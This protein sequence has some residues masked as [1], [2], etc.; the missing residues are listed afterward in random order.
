MGIRMRLR[1]GEEG[2]M[3]LCRTYGGERK[4]RNGGDRGVHNAFTALISVGNEMDCDRRKKSSTF[5]RPSKKVWY[6][7]IGK[8]GNSHSGNTIR[9]EIQGKAA[10]K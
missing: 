2:V 1:G 5:S 7:L 9:K 4:M 10:K 8:R 3:G 6:F